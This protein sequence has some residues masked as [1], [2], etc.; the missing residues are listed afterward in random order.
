[1]LPIATAAPTSGTAAARHCTA[2]D[3]PGERV[4]SVGAGAGPEVNAI[5]RTWRI[6]GES[7]E[8]DG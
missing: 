8:E 3:E 7:A 2:E 5:A 1:M 4:G 6:D